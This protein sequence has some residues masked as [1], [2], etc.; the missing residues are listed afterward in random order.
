MELHEY[1]NFED[2]DPSPWVA[3]FRARSL[4]NECWS[5]FQEQHLARSVQSSNRSAGSVHQASGLSKKGVLVSVDAAYSLSTKSGAGAFL[6]RNHWGVLI[7]GHSFSLE[8]DSALAAEA[9]TLRAAML[10]AKELQFSEVLFE[11]DCE[12]L[13]SV[14]RKLS[15]AWEVEV[16]CNDIQ[17]YMSSFSKVQVVKISRLQNG[18]AHWVAAKRVKGLLSSDIFFN[19]DLYLQKILYKDSSRVSSLFPSS[20]SCNEGFPSCLLARC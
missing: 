15:K 10:R 14:C 19:L 12:T 4:N 20:F 13:V 5:A 1:E 7:D 3:I 18:A 8:A 16:I 11:T 6:F 2:R 17:E 9:L